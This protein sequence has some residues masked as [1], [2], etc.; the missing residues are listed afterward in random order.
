MKPY[1]LIDARNGIFDSSS[2]SDFQ[3]CP[4]RFYHRWI[5]GIVPRRTAAAL[6]AGEQV[7]RC[8]AAFTQTS[9][10]ET[11]IA[12]L[13]GDGAEALWTLPTEGPEA[14][15]HPLNLEKVMRA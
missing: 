6:N 2:L 5:R 9:D 15:R 10:V 11:S 3:R 8:L 13:K 12:T 14:K 4:R 7:H 1:T